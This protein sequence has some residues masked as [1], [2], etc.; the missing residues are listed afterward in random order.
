MAL[1]PKHICAYP[2]CGA[3]IDGSGSRCSKHPKPRDYSRERP[4]KHHSLYTT[5]EWA[6]ARRDFLAA[7]P[8]CVYC[9]ERGLSMSA[10]VVDHIVPH[11]G[12]LGLFW[13]RT[14]WQGLCFN[15]HNHRKKI[16]ELRIY[17]RE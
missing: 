5:K 14:N 1:A 13:D 4:S 6:A 15:C 7:R 2:G 16:L 3:L 11:R 17:G 9:A 10:T 12:N 8:T